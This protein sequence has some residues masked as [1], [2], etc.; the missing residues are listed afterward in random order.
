MTC[1]SVH[2]ERKQIDVLEADVIGVNIGRERT[3]V[4]SV[5]RQYDESFFLLVVSDAFDTIDHDNLL[6]IL[7]RYVGISG[8]ALRLIRSYFCDRTQRVQIN[9]S[10]SDFASLLCGV[11]LGS[12]LGSMK[13]CL[14]LHPL[15]AILRNHIIVYHADETHLIEM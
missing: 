14:Y 6:Y 8:S 1:N 4:N 10:M 12:V 7:E 5:V 15:G 3:D 11:L 2:L 13:F 9:G